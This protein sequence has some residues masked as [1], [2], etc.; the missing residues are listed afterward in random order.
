M[1][2]ATPRPIA[3]GFGLGLLAI[4]LLGA[5]RDDDPKAAADLKA[6]Q[7]AWTFE[8]ADRPDGK[9][10]FDGKILKAEVGDESYVA[11]VTL[12]PDAKPVPEI[13]FLVTEGP[14]EAKGTTRRGIYRLEGKTLTIC[15]AN[16][17]KPRPRTFELVDDVQYLFELTR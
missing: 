8:S 7:G 15:V 16:E 1:T 14:E 5:G 9:F 2:N 6:V 12:R 4:A 13:D 11:E 3:T 17:G 10:T